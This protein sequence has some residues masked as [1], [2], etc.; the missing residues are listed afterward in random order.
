MKGP[1][2]Y[3]VTYLGTSHDVDPTQYLVSHF[4]SLDAEQ[5]PCRAERH[6]CISAAD[7]GDR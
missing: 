7:E 5:C 2:P 6:V 1:R 4:A 3:Q